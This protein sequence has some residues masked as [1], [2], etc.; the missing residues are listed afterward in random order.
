MIN[1]KKHL[2]LNQDQF[3][4]ILVYF[5]KSLLG[6]KNEEAILWDLAK[7]C[8]SKLGFIDC[9]IY[10]IDQKNKSLVQKAAYGPKNPKDYLVYN[11]VEIKLGEGI[12]GSV[13]VSGKA[14]II[15]DT[16]KDPRYIVDD[17]TRLSE[18]TVPI[19]TDNVIYGVIDCEHPDKGFFTNQHLKMLS[20][21]AS[22]C[23]IK[24]KSVRD[25]NALLKEQQNLLQLKEEMLDLKLRVFKSQMNPHFVFN[26]LNAIQ[27]F[28]VSENKKTALQYLSVFS[29]LI[30]FYLTHLEKETVDLTEEITMLNWYLTLQ[31]LRYNNTFDYS[32]SFNQKPSKHLNVKIPSFILQ[33]LFENLIEHAI[34]NQHKN[35][36][37]NIIF[38]ISPSNI[39]VNIHY[40]Y[41]TEIIDK[42]RYTPEYR[43]QIVKC[44]DLIRSVNRIKKYKIKKKVIPILNTDK[45]IF[46]NKITLTFPNI[47]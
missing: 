26:A 30:R 9:V 3:E 14:E 13:A 8:I 46:G 28:I 19:A 31:K 41:T 29:K 36:T 1:L 7:N 20:A 44:L 24:I 39:I 37:I 17:E 21:I 16:S 23:A 22:I 42:I 40:N 34:H 47:E 18:I 43:K 6:K 35:Q 38:E 27:Y 11:P 15:Y 33:T 5:S 45:S 32:I 4:D 10:L 12:T 2:S 25:T